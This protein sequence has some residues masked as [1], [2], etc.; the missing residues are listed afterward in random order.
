MYASTQIKP[1][2]ASLPATGD[3][4]WK[5]MMRGSCNRRRNVCLIVRIYCVY[6]VKRSRALIK[7][8]SIVNICSFPSKYYH[9]HLQ[10]CIGRNTCII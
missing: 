9:K 6:K 2:L 8:E 3:I 5:R 10:I 7:L 1:A 4:L